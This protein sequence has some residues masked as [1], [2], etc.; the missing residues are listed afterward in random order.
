MNREQRAALLAEEMKAFQALFEPYLEGLLPG[1]GLEQQTVADAMRYSLLAG[2]KRIRPFL[3]V[4]CHKLCGGEPGQVLPLAAAL[5]MIHTYSL[6]HDDLPCMDND[7]YRRG[8]PTSHKVFGEAMAVLAG[9]GLLTAAFE[10]ALQARVEPALLCKAV[11]ELGRAAGLFGMLGGQSID[12]ESEKKRLSL[13][14]AQML[15]MYAMTTGALLTGACRIGFAAAGVSGERL[16]IV[17]E[18]ARELGLTFQIVDDMLDK[19]GDFAL[20]GK[21]IG[22]DEKNQKTTFA[23]LYSLEQCEALARQ[24]TEAAVGAAQRLP[25]SDVLVALAEYLLE[26]KK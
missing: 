19:T 2:G 9:D 24:H 21:P 5:E 13:D 20:L 3:L 10:T 15:R 23:T 17:T 8:R 14:E 7:D 4:S 11:Q 16:E 6:I 25:D 1:E 22:S 26:R 12:V 18:Y